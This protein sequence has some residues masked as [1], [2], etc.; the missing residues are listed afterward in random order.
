MQITETISEALHRE[1]KVLVP[2]GDLDAKLTGRLEEMKPKVHLKGFRPGKAP[3]SFL[4][5]SF[6]KSMMGEIVDEAVNESSKRALEDNGLK[7][8]SP[9]RVQLGSD[10]EDVARG[11]SDLE[12][13]LAVDLM[14]DFEPTELTMLQVQRL[15]STVADS[16]V[17]EAV[18]RLAEQSRTY[19]PRAEGEAESGD[20]VVID[21]VGRVDGEEF[22]G[23]KAE[24]FNLVLGSGQLVAGFE[25]QLIGAKAA[26]VRDVNITFPA[27]YPEAK[28]AGKDAVFSVTVKEIKKP[29][30]ITVDDDTAK[31]LGLESLSML[32]E[33]VRD[34]MR[35]DYNRASRMHLKRRILDALDSAHSF[36]L[37]S[38]MVEQEFEGIWQAVQAELA[39]EGA[40]AD[41]EGKSEEE[42]KKEY[43]DIAERRVRLGLVLAKIGE[44]NGLQVSPEEVNRAAAA[45][46]RQYAMQSQQNPSQAISEQQA[47]KMLVENPQAMAE[48]RA[49]LF[50]EKVVDFIAELAQ[51]EDVPV[52][53]E[54]LFLDPD[55]AEEK[56]KAA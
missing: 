30:P 16:D 36:P 26:D 33:R 15:V 37:P 38:G 2:R 6:G 43:H 52:D 53:R 1:F 44:Q 5:K 54:T 39:R 14:P 31:K 51:I 34:Q 7:P 22:A 47:Y 50:E 12:F 46:A 49:P 40:G 42:L 29:D 11:Q 20:A 8:A 56:L 24:D 21:F 48:I 3:V 4:K 32:R 19:S 13:T 10:M 41:E 17:D 35:Q 27:D 25:D 9:P 23:G 55:A 28:L 45:R 18:N